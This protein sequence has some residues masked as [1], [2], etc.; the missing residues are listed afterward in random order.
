MAEQLFQFGDLNTTDIIL[1]LIST[2]CRWFEQALRIL[3]LSNGLTTIRIW[4]RQ[5]DE[6]AGREYGVMF[7]LLHFKSSQVI[8]IL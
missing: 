3:N 2:D 5:K 4:R 6:T 1:K 7:L 8:L